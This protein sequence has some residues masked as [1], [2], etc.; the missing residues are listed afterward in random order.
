MRVLYVF[1]DLNVFI[2]SL[3]NKQ[4]LEFSLFQIIACY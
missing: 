3:L 4:E 2:I 1:L